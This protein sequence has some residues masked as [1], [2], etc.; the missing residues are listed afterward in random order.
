MDR[1]VDILLEIFTWIGLGGFLALSA[2]AVILWAAD[3]TWLPAD[4]IVDR[5]GDDPVLR[6]FDGDG[7]A[8]SAVPA[9]T[10]HAVIGSRATVPIWY[11]HGWRDRMRLTPRSPA[12]RAA[13]LGAGAMLALAIVT[14][15]AGLIVL[16][17]A[18]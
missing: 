8:N 16:A 5:D 7:D 18:G 11:R 4:A 3:G 2:V 10:D 17:A 14:F 13:I 15:V 12:L 6:W 9:I 1:A